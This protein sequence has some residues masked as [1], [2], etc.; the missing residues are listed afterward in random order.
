MTLGVPDRVNNTLDYITGYTI[1][2][3]DI[4]IHL[5]RSTHSIYHFKLNKK[6]K[7]IPVPFLDI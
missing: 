2:L 3:S 6:V 5:Y 4:D 7:D 1:S